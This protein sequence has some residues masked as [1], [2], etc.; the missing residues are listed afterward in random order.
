MAQDLANLGHFY[1]GGQATAA[2]SYRC[3]PKITEKIE[4]SGNLWLSCDIKEA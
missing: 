4:R 3:D 1:A 2:R